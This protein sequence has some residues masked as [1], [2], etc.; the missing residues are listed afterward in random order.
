MAD[1]GDDAIV[2]RRVHD[3]GVRSRLFDQ[4][5]EEP[6]ALRGRVFVRGEDVHRV[7][8]EIRIGCAHAHPLR[9]R[10]GMSSDKGNVVAPLR[11]QRLAD[12]LFCAAG[13]RDDAAGTHVWKQFKYRRHDGRDGR[14]D[15]H[16]VGPSDSL[17]QVTRG[18]IA[19]A[20]RDG[21]VAGLWPPHDAD[22]PVGPRGGSPGHAQRTADKPHTDD[23]D[24]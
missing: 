2:A 16:D 5:A 12:M 9:T 6:E 1:G 18:F 3:D 17:G 21:F 7:L 22:H 15:D 13:V 14:A 11:P 4:A 24:V 20:Q 23:R 8:K 19:C 10:H